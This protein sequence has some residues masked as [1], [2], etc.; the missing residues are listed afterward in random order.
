MVTVC[1]ASARFSG[2][3][4]L[5]C[6]IDEIWRSTPGQRYFRWPGRWGRRRRQ[7][8]E[9]LHRVAQ[10]DAEKLTFGQAAQKGPDT[11]RRHPSVSDGYPARCEAH[12]ARGETC[13]MDVGPHTECPGT[14][15]P[16][17]AIVQR[18][19]SDERQDVYPPGLRCVCRT[20]RRQ[21]KPLG[22]LYQS[23]GVHPL[24]APAV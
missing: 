12:P 17:N 21:A 13:M 2:G 9:P 6:K 24:S 22:D 1:A 3:K 7:E 23:P 20:G 18:R 19:H 8:Q 14:M 11:R 4:E 5:P 16:T 10:Q 15:G